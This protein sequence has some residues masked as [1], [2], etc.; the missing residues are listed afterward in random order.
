MTQNGISCLIFEALATS[1]QNLAF[2]EAMIRSRKV[3]YNVTRQYCSGDA[4]FGF[5]RCVWRPAVRGICS[6]MF[7]SAACLS[8]SWYMSLK[9]SSIWHLS[10]A[11]THKMECQN[12]LNQKSDIPS[13]SLNI[14]RTHFTALKRSRLTFC[15][16]TLTAAVRKITGSAAR[17]QTM[18][19][20]DVTQRSKDSALFQV[21][22]SESS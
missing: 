11:M 3:A 10:A 9:V 20:N 2:N 4:T 14:R 15:G 18:K 17:R 8:A 6:T 19:A 7:K 21:D 1:A 22:S 5:A 13:N 16:A 12:A